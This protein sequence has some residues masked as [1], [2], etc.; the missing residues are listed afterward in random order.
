MLGAEL[1]T[2]DRKLQAVMAHEVQQRA[3]TR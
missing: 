1:L 3:G 2:H